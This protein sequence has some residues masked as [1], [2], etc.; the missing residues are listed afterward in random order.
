[1][2]QIGVM[3]LLATVTIGGCT[4]ATQ[5]ATGPTSPV[6]VSSSGVP[7]A[8]CPST[9]PDDAKPYDTVA[10]AQD[11]IVPGTP[12]GLVICE[13]RIGMDRSRRFELDA[14]ATRT[15]ARLLDDLGPAPSGVF[16]C[17]AERTVPLELFFSYANGARLLV[18]APTTGC[19]FASNGYVTVSETAPFL[20][21]LEMSTTAS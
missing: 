1:M 8:R 3:L 13:Y 2:R 10:G 7:A 14:A 12:S 15:I 5:D 9:P 17:P 21:R 4:R 11:R 19:L 16:A 6:T 18:I 20:R